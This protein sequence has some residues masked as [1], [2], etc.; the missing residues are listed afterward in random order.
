MP[1]LLLLD[2][3]S[4]ADVKSRRWVTSEG[5]NTGFGKL[6]A[7]NDLRALGADPL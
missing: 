3:V 7:M 5:L 1:T 2:S 4:A 6:L